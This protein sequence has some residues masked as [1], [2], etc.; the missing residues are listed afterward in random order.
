MNLEGLI[1]ISG[2]N[3]LYKVISNSKNMIIVESLI[4]KKR[5]PIHSSNQANMLEEI[6]IYTYDDTKPLSSVFENIAKKENYNQTISHKLSKNELIEFFRQIVPDFDEEKVYISD[7]KKVIQWYNL[8]QSKKIIKR[9]EKKKI[10]K[11]KK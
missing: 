9:K 11:K 3:G 4:D 7:I 8:L 5:T 10:T 2:K 1:N 6:G